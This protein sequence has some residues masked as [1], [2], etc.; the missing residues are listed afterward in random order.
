[1]KRKLLVMWCF[2][3]IVTYSPLAALAPAL[4]GLIGMGITGIGLCC[5]VSFAGPRS[6]PNT[7]TL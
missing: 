7:A 3:V 6:Y 5:S 4:L 2:L 1:M